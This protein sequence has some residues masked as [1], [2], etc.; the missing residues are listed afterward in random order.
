[1]L[2]RVGTRIGELEYAVLNVVPCSANRSMA[3][4]MHKRVAIT[5]QWVLLMFVRQDANK[6]HGAHGLRLLRGFKG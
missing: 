1:M 3:G 6:V 4:G 5:S 2:A